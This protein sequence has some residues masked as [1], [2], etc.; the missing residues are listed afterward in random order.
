MR[1][2]GEQRLRAALDACLLNDEEWREWE[3][4]MSSKAKGL[5]TEEE[6]KEALEELF[7]DGFEEWLDDEENGHEH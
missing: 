1:N 4:V 5:R 2:G 6:K 3:R 7:E